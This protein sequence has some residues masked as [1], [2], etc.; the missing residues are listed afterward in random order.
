VE[1]VHEDSGERAEVN[2]AWLYQHAC[3]EVLEDLYL[4]GRAEL[5]CKPEVW[6][7]LK[8]SRLVA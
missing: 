8:T 2:L 1:L 4:K 5:I 3:R 6:H 7:E